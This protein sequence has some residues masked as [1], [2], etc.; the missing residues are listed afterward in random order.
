[1]LSGIKTGKRK[2]PVGG[3]VA[4]A[5]GSR[6][7]TGDI[8][9]NSSSNEIRGAPPSVAKASFASGNKSGADELR[10]SLLSVIKSSLTKTNDASAS[11]SHLESRGRISNEV[12]TKEQDTVVINQPRGSAAANSNTDLRYNSKG[13]LSRLQQN[14]LREKTDADLT[15]SE[16]I[17]QER[18]QTS[19]DEIYARNIAK[20]GKGYK[21]YDNMTH[22]SRSGADEEDYLQTSTLLTDRLYRN[23]PSNAIAPSLQEQ[24]VKSR[25][26]AQHSAFDKWKS[27]SW[28]WMESPSFDKKFLIALG[29]KVSLVLVPSKYA[30]VEGHCYIVPLSYSESFVNLDEEV[31][32]EVNRFQSSLKQ[33]F[34]EKKK[35]LI[36]LETASRTSKSGGSAGLQCRMEV[37]P[38]P[39]RT[40]EDA[41]FYFK[42]SLSEIAQEWGTHQMAIVLNSQKTL[43]NAVPRGF[44]YFYCGWNGGGY[45]QLIEGEDDGLGGSGDVGGSKYRDFGLDTV[46]GMMGLD[47]YRMRKKGKGGREDFEEEKKGIL[48][49][50]ERWKEFDWTTE[51][52]G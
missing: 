17:Q 29:D 9:C 52:D 21:K 13:K 15:I 35:G 20:M 31:W 3:A 27:K 33:M 44:P 18:D 46:S 28:W 11:I 10:A 6:P 50:C 2:R 19:M 37:V 26:L 7:A 24:K 12:L 14:T 51:L 47:P 36:F 38:V 40:E 43:R 4:A 8:D 32:Y 39:L 23:A 16:M 45:V 22:N 5:A 25:T 42:S 48:Q 30:L 1:M 41:P 34:A 49:F